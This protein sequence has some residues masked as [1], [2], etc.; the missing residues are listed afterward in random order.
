MLRVGPRCARHG[1][2]GATLTSTRILTAVLVRV[3]PLDPC[4]R[5]KGRR[6]H[7]R[8]CG[9]RMT[10]AR[11]AFSALSIP[12]TS[13]LSRRSSAADHNELCLHARRLDRASDRIVV[14]GAMLVAL[15]PLWF[16]VVLLS[17]SD[18][19][20]RCRCRRVNHAHLFGLAGAP[21][22]TYTRSLGN[23]A[24]CICTIWSSLCFPIDVI[25]RCHWVEGC[26][27][28]LKVSR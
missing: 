9:M 12:A 2:S 19:R 4:R 26:A 11:S 15:R 24:A 14:R 7:P 8:V 21:M 18:V 5:P 23:P 13:A 27:G 22:R 17:A 28:L 1:S 10:S 20:Q 25:A 16:G 3:A 6:A